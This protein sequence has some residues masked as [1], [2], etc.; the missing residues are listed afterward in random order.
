MTAVSAFMPSS[1]NSVVF[2][3]RSAR[4]AEN[5]RLRRDGAQALPRASVR[6]ASMCAASSA[7]WRRAAAAAAPKAAM[8]ATFSVP[9]RS[10]RS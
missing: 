7:S 9:A 6:N 3:S 4:G 5:H 10:P 1:A 2:G 8:P